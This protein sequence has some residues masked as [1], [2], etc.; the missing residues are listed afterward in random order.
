MRALG[1]EPTK[2]EVQALLPEGAYQTVA[3]NCNHCVDRSIDRSSLKVCVYSIAITLI[4]RP[5]RFRRATVP[6]LR[7]RHGREDGTEG[8][9]GGAAQGLQAIHKRRRRLGQGMLIM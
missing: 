1:F 9:Q 5:Q 4:S 8:L 7:A 6:R 2:Q 3:A